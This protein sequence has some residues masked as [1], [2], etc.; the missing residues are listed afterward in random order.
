MGTPVIS[1][2][3]NSRNRISKQAGVNLD[4]CVFTADQDII[5]WEARADGAGQGQGLLVGGASGANEGFYKSDGTVYPTVSNDVMYCDYAVAVKKNAN[6]SF[7]VDSTELTNGD[8][9][10]RINI[11]AKNRAGNW[12]PYGG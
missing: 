9:T 8:K 6:R 11:Y 12:T 5:A 7:D 1:L 2:V 3:S 10:Y 4:T